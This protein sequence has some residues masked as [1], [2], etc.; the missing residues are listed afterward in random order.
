MWF[1]DYQDQENDSYFKTERVEQGGQGIVGCE[2]QER[3]GWGEAQQ[4]E[5][6]RQRPRKPGILSMLAGWIFG[7]DLKGR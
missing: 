2:M 5:V 7:T 4:D 1:K 6:D 3:L